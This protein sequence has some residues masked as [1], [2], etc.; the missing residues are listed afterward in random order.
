MSNIKVV[1]AS[2]LRKWNNQSYFARFIDKNRNNCNGLNL[3][4]VLLKD[5]LAHFDTWECDIDFE[6]TI[7]EMKVIKC[8]EWRK[9]LYFDSSGQITHL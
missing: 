2:V 5:A 1:E 6:M 3:Q 8:N 7:E 9:H 4:W